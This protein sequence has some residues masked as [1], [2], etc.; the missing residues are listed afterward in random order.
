LVVSTAPIVKTFNELIP[1]PVAEKSAMFEVVNRLYSL[2]AVPIGGF[3]AYIGL[4]GSQCDLNL[5]S[6]NYFWLK[7]NNPYE[8]DYY[9]SLSLPKALEYGSPPIIFITFPSAKDPTWDD[10]H[11]GKFSSQVIRLSSGTN[12]CES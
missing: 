3:Q 12:H 6:S 7:N 2:E 4:T 10:R 11:P 8:V 9:L 5:P 1:R